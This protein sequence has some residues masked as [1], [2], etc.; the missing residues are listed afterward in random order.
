MIYS[1]GSR[2]YSS[3]LTPAPPAMPGK[4]WFS[5]FLMLCST[6]PDAL[7]SKQHSSLRKTQV[8][9]FLQLTA[10]KSFN[11][12]EPLPPVK[13]LLCRVAGLSMAIS[14]AHL[15]YS[16]RSCRVVRPA[17]NTAQDTNVSSRGGQTDPKAH[18]KKD[19]SLSPNS[20][21]LLDLTLNPP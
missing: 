13:S 16:L 21:K 11:F 3:I 5:N 9:P 19:C 2:A 6:S 1:Q 20:R 8:P 15:S 10:L 4:L 17:L 18:G 12:G 14:R 7:T